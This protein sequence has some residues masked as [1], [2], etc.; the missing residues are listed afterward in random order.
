MVYTKGVLSGKYKGNEMFGGLLHTLII[1]SNKEQQGVGMQN[2][3][4]RANI[5][6]FAHIIQTHST[7]AY[8]TIKEF[9]PL[10]TV[11]TLQYVSCSFR[12]SKCCNITRLHWAKQLHFPIGIQDK[13]YD[14]ACE[15]LRQLGYEGPVALSCDDTKL[16]ASLC[17]YYNH[18]REGYY[19]MGH[20]GE[21][22]LLPDPEAF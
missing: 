4:Y 6:E 3:T 1:K 7:R 12:V 19:L 17:P 16:L 10:P 18:D 14:L 15:R 20:I 2:F 5:V 13:T 21:P 11:R 9:L 22:L 8:N